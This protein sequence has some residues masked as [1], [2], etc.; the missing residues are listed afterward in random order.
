VRPYNAQHEDL[1]RSSRDHFAAVSTKAATIARRFDAIRR[2]ST[3]VA[4]AK[5]DDG[6]LNGGAQLAEIK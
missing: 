1:Q 6:Q 4:V 3:A 5:V 2:I